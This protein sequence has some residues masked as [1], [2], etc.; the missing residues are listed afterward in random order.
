MFLHNAL[1]KLT[2]CAT[3]EAGCTTALR[4]NDKSIAKRSRR[5]PLLSCPPEPLRRSHAIAPLHS[6]R[7]PK[8]IDSIIAKNCADNVTEKDGELRLHDVAF[9][10]ALRD[11]MTFQAAVSS[12]GERLQQPFRRG[13]RSAKAPPL[14]CR[15]RA[16]QA[17]EDRQRRGEEFAIEWFV[18][19]VNR[20]AFAQATCLAIAELASSGPPSQVEFGS[21][22]MATSSFSENGEWPASRASYHRIQTLHCSL[23]RSS[24]LAHNSIQSS[25][26]FWSGGASQSGCVR[27]ERA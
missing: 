22:T 21:A 13:F 1:L 17:T 20:C 15:N 23:L 26:T 3:K 11:R 12:S 16:S 5:L 19:V 4:R 25:D 2:G 9:V 24:G 18:N 10:V 7:N 6:R 8:K 14:G 27:R